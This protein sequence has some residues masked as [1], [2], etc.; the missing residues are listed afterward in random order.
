MEILL[1]KLRDGSSVQ[2]GI[3]PSFV[4]AN[5]ALEEDYEDRPGYFTSYVIEPQQQEVRP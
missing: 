5:E 2:L 4:L 1:G 3:F